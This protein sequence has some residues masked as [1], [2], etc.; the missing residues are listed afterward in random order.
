MI[1]EFE[2]AKVKR[3]MYAETVR[4]NLEMLEAIKSCDWN[5]EMNPLDVIVQGTDDVVH[6][7]STG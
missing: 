7:F 2:S 3:S 1:E 6:N 4:E 5:M